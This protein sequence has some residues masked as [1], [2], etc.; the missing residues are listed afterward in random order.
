MLPSVPGAR[1]G[2]VALLGLDPG[3]GFAS[4]EVVGPAVPELPGL[5]VPREVGLPVALGLP[6]EP[7]LPAPLG[8]LVELELPPEPADPPLE[9][10][11][12][13]DCATAWPTR[14]PAIVNVAN[15]NVRNAASLRVLSTNVRSYEEFPF[16]ASTRSSSRGTA[17]R[18]SAWACFKPAL[19]QG[20]AGTRSPVA[21]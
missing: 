14:S 2:A 1:R 10:P 8:E 7:A 18:I 20:C 13:P 9:P 5:A 19:K 11:E 21:Y 15:V 17:S 4:P 6:A 12:L 16:S 3:D